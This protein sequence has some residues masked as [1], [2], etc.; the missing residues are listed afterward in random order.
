MLILAR[1]GRTAANAQGLLQGRM[2][3][4]LDEVGRGQA[5]KLAVALASVDVIISS[6]LRRAMET[7]EAL[8]KDIEVDERWQELDF[9]CLDGQRRQDI[10][11][12]VWKRLQQDVHY[13]P[14]GGESLAAMMQRVTPALDELLARSADQDIVVFTHV[15]PIK[16]AFSHVLNVGMET[17]RRTYLDQA[18]ITRLDASPFGPVL[19]SFNET[20]HLRVP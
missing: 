12:A 11:V 7:A 17:G 3:L 13:A 5:Q 19:H 16:A 1:H 14:D 15:M 18:S 9:G 8:G 6:P 20:G 10:D 2:D 4:S